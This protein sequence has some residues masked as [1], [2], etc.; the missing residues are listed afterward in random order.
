MM[1]LP[2]LDGRMNNARTSEQI[3]IRKDPIGYDIIN[4]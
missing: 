1:N 3:R 2:I 4:N